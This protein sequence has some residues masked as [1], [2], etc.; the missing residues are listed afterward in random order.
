[1][2]ISR[3]LS[4]Y[5]LLLVLSGLTIQYSAPLLAQ[6]NDQLSQLEK[7]KRNLSNMVKCALSKEGCTEG[8]AQR[9]RATIGTIILLI[10]I[11][12][13]I[14]L[15]VYLSR[16]DKGESMPKPQIPAGVRGYAEVARQSKPEEY[17][18]RVE[19]P[20]RWA[21]ERWQAAQERAKQWWWP[22]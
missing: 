13:G 8:Q 21:Q 17:R 4:R 3:T 2:K 10:M 11:I 20:F 9:I 22:K 5:L 7:A 1:M 15:G 6:N 12:A 14:G 19:I 16:R 18:R